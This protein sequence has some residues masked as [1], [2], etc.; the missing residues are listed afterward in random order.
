VRRQA[1]RLPSLY[2]LTTAGKG[3]LREE[4]AEPGIEQLWAYTGHAASVL[5]LEHSYLVGR[6]YAALTVAATRDGQQVRACSP[7]ETCRH[8]NRRRSRRAAS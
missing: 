1:K 2:A 7:P 6:T 4:L 3:Y 8:W 5:N